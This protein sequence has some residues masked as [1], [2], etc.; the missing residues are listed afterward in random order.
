VLTVI[1]IYF[2]INHW[3][4]HLQRWG[5]L[6]ED[7][8]EGE[9]ESEM[10]EGAE[11]AL[12]S[13]PPTSK[14]P[15]LPEDAESSG[16]EKTPRLYGTVNSSTKHLMP[17]EVA[18]DY[19]QPWEQTT[20]LWWLV[21]WVT[22]VSLMLILTAVR[23]PGLY[24]FAKHAD[25]WM[26][27]VY[28]FLAFMI[29]NFL[30][31]LTARRFCETDEMGYVVTNKGSWFKINYTR[32]LQHFLSMFVPLL[33]AVHY[34]LN[35]LEY[36]WNNVVMLTYHTMLIKPIRESFSPVMLMFTSI[37]RPE[38]RPHTLRLSMANV[39][40]GMFISLGMLKLFQMEGNPSLMLLAAMVAIVGDGLAEPVGINLGKHK[41]KCNSAF[42]NRT[43]VRSWEGSACVHF[44]G[45]F[46]I[47]VYAS[48][49]DSFLQTVIAMLV[50]PPLTAWVESVSPHTIDA[51][52]LSLTTGG[53]LL[54]VVHFIP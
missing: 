48:A 25:F 20:D 21:L 10:E 1:L 44:A 53:V 24:D 37:D 29:V 11:V 47:A 30:G 2:F 39:V 41:Y 45:V 9:K 13:V 40:P 3:L 51:P 50:L 49:F 52:F 54:F 38:D 15:L 42:G 8:G 26:M 12:S 18:S 5:V 16:L 22:F 32:K 19:T 46:F 36:A 28:E 7:V 23:Q 4:Q 35:T 17:G 31:G 34:E 27:M 6:S 43:Y 33:I 14:E